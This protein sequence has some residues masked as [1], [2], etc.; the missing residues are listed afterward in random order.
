MKTAIQA[1]NQKD[2]PRL[3]EERDQYYKEAIEIQEQIK[4]ILPSQRVDAILR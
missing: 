4:S 3:R 1:Y 2:I